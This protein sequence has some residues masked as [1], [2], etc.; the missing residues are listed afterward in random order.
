MTERSK[1]R[2]LWIAG[3]AAFGI[4]VILSAPASLGAAA[5]QAR[6]PGLFIG[7]ASGTL[8]SGRFNA[9]AYDG[10]DLGQIDFRL[11]PL[12]GLTGALGASVQAEGG[13]LVGKGQI[14]L[15][16]KRV[17][18]KNLRARFNLSAIRRYSFYGLRYSGVADI[19]ATSLT[20][21]ANSCAADAV[22]I[23]TNLVDSLTKQWRGEP[24]PLSGDAVCRGSDLLVRL[25]GE[26]PDGTLRAEAV[27]KHDLA[28]T[29]ELTATP[30]RRE[31]GAALRLYGF[32]GRNDAMTLRAAG[33]LKGLTV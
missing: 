24:M 32:E 26:N 10:I 6:A 3:V 16:A 9:V 21:S 33:Q 5:L 27:L 7:E 30:K 25:A 19:S 31:F 2:S 17:S 11:N 23:T 22:T 8:W 14:S 12:A 1:T 29:L 4:A 28:Y 18:V 13:A 20:L 15:T